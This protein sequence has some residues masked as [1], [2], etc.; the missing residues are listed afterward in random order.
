MRQARR[1]AVICCPQLV[2]EKMP[3]WSKAAVILGSL[4]PIFPFLSLIAVPMGAVVLV[5]SRRQPE[6][7]IGRGHV[8]EGSRA[9]FFAAE[10]FVDHADRSLYGLVNLAFSPLQE[11]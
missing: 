9:G 4:S 11:T 8:V 1:D 7:W 6:Y 5:R 2:W 3:G 10:R